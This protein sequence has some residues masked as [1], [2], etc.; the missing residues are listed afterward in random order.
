MQPTTDKHSECGL[1]YLKGG[2]EGEMSERRLSNS[3]LFRWA[4][5]N[6]PCILLAA[7][8]LF[9]FRDLVLTR[10]IPL[11]SDLHIYYYPAWNFFGK[12]LRSGRLAFWCDHI[13]SG[14]PLFSDSEAGIFYPV[15]AL[16][17]LLPTVAGF[18]LIFWLHYL[19]AGLF[20]YAYLRELRVSRLSASLMALPY[21]LG[22][23]ALAHLV[24]I[25]A[26][27]AVAWLPLY[28]LF[29][30]RGMKERK[31]RSFVFAGLILG[32]QFLAGF[33][34]VPLFGL[35]IT[36]FY[37]F[38]YPSR[39]KGRWRGAAFV[40]KALLLVGLIGFGIGMV[41][42]LPSYH[43][44]KE[45]YRAQGLP[46]QVANILN[47]PAPQLLTFFFPK[48][49]GQGVDQAYWGAWY[50]EDLYGYVGIL[51]LF[52]AAFALKRKRSWHA[53]FFF[54][55]L[56][57]SAI[58]ALGNAGLLWRLIHL[59]P[60]FNV[61]KAPCRFL[62]LVDLSLLV[63]GGI[64]LDR[65]LEKRREE[66]RNMRRMAGV[67]LRL[68]VAW[69]GVW[70]G[71]AVLLR[72]NP[73]GFT[74]FFEA[75]SRRIFSSLPGDPAH[76]YQQWTSFLGLTNYRFALPLLLAVVVPL[77]VWLRE[78]GRVTTRTLSLALAIVV[79]FEAFIWGGNIHR[80]TS[81]S[82]VRS[83]PPAVDAISGDEDLY[84]VTIAKEPRA[85]Q[86]EEFLFAPDTLM[87][88]GF[89]DPR[90]QSTVPPFKYDCFQSWIQSLEP[91]QI[92]NLLNVRYLVAQPVRSGGR[93][94]D[95]S[96]PEALSGA[97]PRL[98][99]PAGG[100]TIDGVFM[101]SHLQGGGL[102][103]EG[104]PVAWV[105]VKGEGVAY[106]PYP[107][108][109]GRETEQIEAEE[110]VR[111]EKRPSEGL[112]ILEYKR[113][114]WRNKAWSY[115]GTLDFNMK[116][117]A[118]SIE[119]ELDKGMYD[120][121]LAIKSISLHTP[122][123]RI[124]PLEKGEVVYSGP[125]ITVYQ[126]AHAL[127]RAFL[128]GGLVV[129]E[130]WETSL[131]RAF[132]STLDLRN[133]VAIED[134]M[135]DPRLRDA[136]QT[137]GA[138]RRVEG[139]VEI[140]DFSGE[141]KE[142][143][144]EAKEEAVLFIS[145]NYLPG[146]RGILDGEEVPLMRAY[147]CLTAVYIPPGRHRLELAYSPPGLKEGAMIS[148]LALLLSV[149][150][151]F[152]LRRDGEGGT[153]GEPVREEPR[154]GKLP[155]RPGI[156]AFFPAYNDAAT[157]EVLVSRMAEVLQKLTDDYEVIVVDDGS[158]DETANVVERAMMEVPNLR[159]VRHPRNRGYGA[160]LR[161]GFAA[162]TKELVFYTDG[163]GQYDVGELPLLYAKRNEG[164]IV[165]GY[166]IK[167]SDPLYRVVGGKAY[168]FIAR[169]LFGL[170]VRD[171]DCDFRLIRKEALQ[172]IELE[173]KG[174]SICVE[175]VKKLQDKDFTFVEVPV[176]HYKR[177]SG[178]SRFFN[179]RNLV[180]MA[181]SLARLWWRLAFLP[182]LKKGKSDG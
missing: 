171:V 144:V 27:I 6:W 74:T 23:F 4:R 10:K 62:L 78:K 103:E 91:E 97:R 130:D 164:D 21:A 47:L 172:R 16:S 50:F 3:T 63:L 52:M 24:H 5:R 59:L 156:T 72:L 34:M 157:I 128:A 135:L 67:A 25:N 160:A 7:M 149:L 51:P 12:A 28:L 81:T 95:V 31:L 85:E 118:S 173:S 2:K 80:F 108:R 8:I 143:F 11:G 161:S 152:F 169:A 37:L 106:G 55:A 182:R 90:G 177:T 127:P 180:E 122:S 101:L 82:R 69:A 40:I 151:L 56:V 148:L 49:Y 96:N 53:T 60:G 147:G 112:R 123:G 66:R 68:G 134:Q 133:A 46:P 142:I 120:R 33:L 109:V 13:Y 170:R 9:F 158:V 84:R 168:N 114:G 179:L 137:W 35:L 125:K 117:D 32:V 26:V 165:N 64:G 136:A 155:E 105:T 176:H 42:N 121:V 102:L 119:I 104:T 140:A 154:L 94:Y 73:A 99:F 65:L 83:N 100:T 15:N 107:I 30:E 20:F 89:D 19:L 29:M 88:Y 162:A 146:W 70:G 126:N 163:D 175:L 43:L 48:L 87:A 75:I 14:F 132:D 38:L 153:D 113:P 115:E 92:L 18:D 41:Q 167:R 39:G 36:P 138:E 45:S 111:E 79:I 57:L 1:K 86:G 22:G 61:L 174:G 44:V 116:I 178:R 54:W 131:L 76:I 17:F 77:A 93:I 58:A 139:E 124:K 141:C 166:K 129:E 181:G 150:L 98:V 159:L 71:I 110:L 145:Q